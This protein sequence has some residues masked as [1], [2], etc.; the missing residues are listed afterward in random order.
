MRVSTRGA[1]P[2]L[3]DLGLDPVPGRGVDVGSGQ[4]RGQRVE[5]RLLVVGGLDLHSSPT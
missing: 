4:E 2:D 3:P 5:L 1:G